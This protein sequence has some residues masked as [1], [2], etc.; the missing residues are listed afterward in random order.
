MK[1]SYAVSGTLI[2]CALFL[3]ILAT[4]LSVNDARAPTDAY[5]KVGEINGEAK[6]SEKANDIA[7]ETSTSKEQTTSA[8]ERI[9]DI[10]DNLGSR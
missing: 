7:G 2:T 1:T 6:G 9:R 4:V 10:A 5:L 3:V 8:R